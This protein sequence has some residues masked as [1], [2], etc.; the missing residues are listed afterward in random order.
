[1]THF[2][3]SEKKWYN[4][5]H[6]WALGVLAVTESKLY[7]SHPSLSGSGLCWLCVYCTVH[8]S[9]E[10]KKKK[11]ISEFLWCEFREIAVATRVFSICPDTV[12]MCVWGFASVKR[13][14]VFISWRKM[15]VYYSY[16][17]WTDE[18]DFQFQPI[19]VSLHATVSRDC[20]E[21]DF[22]QGHQEN[23][24]SFGGLD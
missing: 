17:K 20:P 1:M 22:P 10:L 9:L 3:P 21:T 6:Q 14:I 7:Y 5:N 4:G 12:C 24:S 13:I 19:K 11:T 18:S 8:R 15:R 16:I 2:T 23:F